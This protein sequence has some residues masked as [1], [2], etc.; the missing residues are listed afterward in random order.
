MAI[1][2]D[3]Y[4]V[5]RTNLYEQIADRLEDIILSELPA[6]SDKLP[7]ETALAEKFNVSRNVVRES[8]KILKE[9]GLI[10]SRNGTGSYIT[11][12][13]AHNLS[14]VINRMVVMDNI[15][16]KDIYDVRIILETAA[17]KRA[18]TRA[19]ARDLKK[20][21]KLLEKLKDKNL[22]VRERRDLDF[23]FH[24]AI[25][26]AAG[27][28]LLVVFVQ[29]MKNVF[30]DLIE[31]GIF[32]QGG[33]DDAIIRHGN[34]LEALKAKDPNMAEVMM[35]DHLHFSKK[36]VESYYKNKTHETE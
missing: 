14:D 1:S 17:C 11:K 7:S 32:I 28:P 26:E 22:S 19:T 3:K 21:E 15:N 12:P 13:E 24:V 20:M 23:D 36:N 9:R 35:Y 8:L 10:E 2:D 34:I 33:I 16:Y 6:G 27:N 4:A 5:V 29:T 25:A 18:A 30:E 31:K